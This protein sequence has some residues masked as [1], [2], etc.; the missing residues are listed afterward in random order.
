MLKIYDIRGWITPTTFFVK[1]LMQSTWILGLDL[2][3]P[4]PDEI[5]SKWK[6]FISTLPTLSKLKF[7]RHLSISFDCMIQII[8]FCDAPS[9]GY[10]ANVYFRSESDDQINVHLIRSESKV[11][12]LKVV[13]IPRLE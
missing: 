6:T 2:D 8:G 1:H 11:A 12:P 9:K 10:A 5:R 7:P 3:D 4:L 13:S